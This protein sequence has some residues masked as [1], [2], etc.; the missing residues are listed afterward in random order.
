ME[1]GSICKNV[2]PYNLSGIITP[3]VR[4]ANHVLVCHNGKQCNNNYDFLQQ[5][6]IQFL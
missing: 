6:H 3:L 4:N 1:F 5:Y 2:K